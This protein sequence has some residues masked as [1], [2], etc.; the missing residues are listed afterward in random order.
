MSPSWP[1]E[2]RALLAELGTSPDRI[3]LAVGGPDAE[4]VTE[5]AKIADAEL[6]SVADRLLRSGSPPKSADEVLQR[7]AG[8]RFLTDLD[9]LFWRTWL[10]LR[11]VAIVR[12]L[13]R[14]S[15]HGIVA[16]WP[17]TVIDCVARYSEPGRRDWF[18]ERLTDAIVLHHKARMFPDEMPY[19]IER[20][21]A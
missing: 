6:V 20:C 9:V 12:R 11:P 10:P 2:G 15:G 4:T 17:G 3:A 21:P 1:E 16:H 8:A 7:L 5:C 19:V 13:G 18:E 14:V